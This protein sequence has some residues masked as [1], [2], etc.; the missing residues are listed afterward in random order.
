MIKI[1][2]NIL[3][4]FLTLFSVSYILLVV[5]AYLPYEEIPINELAESEDR[6]IIIEENQIR[7][8]VFGEQI[9]R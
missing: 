8:R 7:Y 4:I 3:F 2:K 5:Y 1:I 6:F 9:S